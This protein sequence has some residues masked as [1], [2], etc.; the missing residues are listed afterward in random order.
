MGKLGQLLRRTGK[1][2]GEAEGEEGTT[3][4]QRE[5]SSANTTKLGQL[6]REAREEKR[7]TLEHI[8]SATRIRCKYL[9]ALEEGRYDDLPTPGHVHGFLRNYAL[10]LGLDLA[11]VEALFAEDKAAHK[12]FEPGIFRP[13]D[14]ELT[15]PRP[16][17][18]AN[19]VFWFV[20]LLVIVVV[21]GGLFWQYGWP[22]IRPTVTPTATPTATAT[23]ERVVLVPSATATNTPVPPTPTS[24]APTSTPSALT[25][26]PTE[27]PPEPSPTATATH[28]ST[29]ET[30]TPTPPAE[31]S[32]PSAMEGVTLHIT[33][34]E[35]AWLQVTVD[36]QQLP[37][38]LLQAGEERAWQA[39]RSLYFICGNAGGV[40]VTVNGKELG[41]LGA[42]GEVVERLWTPQG[43]V[44]P[45]PTGGET[46]PTPTGEAAP[47]PTP[48]A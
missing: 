8:E 16:L 22:L 15:S 41:T 47:T 40:E 37:G 38:E 28:A 1:R 11:E 5:H 35:R 48:A 24:S 34:T 36:E 30:A 45:T 20:M 33:V 43:E 7:L 13:Q 39:Q 44:T 27:S 14:I 10:H 25:A 46:A 2:A 12:F 21:G 6:L 29:P 9:L 42:R 4:T 19:L 17:I 26:T 32:T 31:T 23:A 18:K 3:Q